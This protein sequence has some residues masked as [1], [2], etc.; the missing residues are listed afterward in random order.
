MDFQFF[1]RLAGTADQLVLCVKFS[2]AK[3]TTGCCGFAGRLCVEG[4]Q[5]PTLGASRRKGPVPKLTTGVL[6]LYSTRLWVLAFP[7]T[8]C[9]LWT[10]RAWSFWLAT[11]H[12]LPLQTNLSRKN[13][14]LNEISIPRFDKQDLQSSLSDNCQRH[15][16]S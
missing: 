5:T 9:A 11:L 14:W 8:Y 6:H 4:S 7:L 10:S 12:A 2:L 13:N 1:R 15:L 3:C 16:T